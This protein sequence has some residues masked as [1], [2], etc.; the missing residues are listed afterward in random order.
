MTEFAY[1]Y[2]IFFLHLVD[3]DEIYPNLHTFSDSHVGW[4]KLQW[5]IEK[6]HLNRFDKYRKQVALNRIIVNECLKW[7]IFFI[8]TLS[9]DKH[10]LR[11]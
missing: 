8:K 7:C 4:K 3:F 6:M 9:V 1:V 11:Y 5:C 2:C 10:W